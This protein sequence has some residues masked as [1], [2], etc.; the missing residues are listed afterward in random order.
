MAEGPLL[1]QPN[2]PNAEP[3]V[4]LIH[5]LARQAI[6]HFYLARHYFDRSQHLLLAESGMAAFDIQIAKSDIL[7][8]RRRTC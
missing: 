5:E 3:P 8:D 4:P 7:R 6:S 2:P 1:A